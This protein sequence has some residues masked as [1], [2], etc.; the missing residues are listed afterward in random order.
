MSL[1]SA[2]VVSVQAHGSGG[3]WPTASLPAWTVVRLRRWPTFGPQIPNSDQRVARRMIT[4]TATVAVATAYAPAALVCRCP[5][6][7]EAEQSRGRSG[8]GHLR[9]WRLA[10]L[11]ADASFPPDA[12]CGVRTLP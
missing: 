4:D 1:W 9:G 11:S 12:T 5:T 6:N 3:S 2:M 10:V 7:M 8:L